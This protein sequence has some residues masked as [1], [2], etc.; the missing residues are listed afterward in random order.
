M[1][2]AVLCCTALLCIVLQCPTLFFGVFFCLSCNFPH[3]SNYLFSAITLLL[4]LSS[5]YGR[6]SVLASKREL[7]GV[8][9]EGLCT[10][11]SVLRFSLLNY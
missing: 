4:D 5:S 2:C 3:N 9:G 7:Q 8:C 1:C 11:D 10:L 6:K